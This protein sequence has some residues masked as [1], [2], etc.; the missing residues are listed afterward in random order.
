[1][2]I[3]VSSVCDQVE[4][5]IVILLRNKVRTV[6]AVKA[7]ITLKTCPPSGTLAPSCREILVGAMAM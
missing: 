2:F 4:Y 6:T 3:A 1:M 5:Q 7:S